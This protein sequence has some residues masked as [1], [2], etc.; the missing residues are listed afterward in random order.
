MEMA[1]GMPLDV[2]ATQARALDPE[3]LTKALAPVSGGAKVTGVEVVEVIRTMATKVRFAVTFA[4]SDAR[5]SFCL[6]AFLDVDAATAR[7]GSTTVKEADFYALIAPH[8]DVRVPDCIA[9]IIDRG[10]EQ[11]LIIM[12]DLIVDGAYFCSALEAFTAQQAAASLEQI[13]RLHAGSPLLADAPWITRRVSE[14][15][16]ME[17]LTAAALQQL[18][19]GPRSVGM[20]ADVLSAERLIAGMRALA[21][22]DA[23]RPQF[24]VHGDAHAGNIY[25]TADG[26]GLIDWQLLQRG[27]WALDVAY[28]IAAVL[29]V[30]VA[31]VEERALL[32]H[33]LGVMRGL[34][35][36]VPDRE[37]AW[38]QYREAAIYGYYLWAITRKVDAPIINLFFN[39]LGSSVARHDSHGLLGIA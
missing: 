25:R 15:A 21:M 13:A 19:D 3:W 11:G 28:H 29:P 30:E 4:G 18:M 16:N 7:G 31:E 38:Q 33:Y 1:D 23:T 39:R 27:G 32:D 37:T 9:S 10:G 5:H 6:K 34:G 17:H 12:R 22:R 35:C 20:D 24:L 36:A 14:L 26:P 2:P 8:I